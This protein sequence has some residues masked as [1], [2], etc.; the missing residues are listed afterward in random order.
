VI[1]ACLRCNDLPGQAVHLN[2]LIN[3]HGSRRDVLSY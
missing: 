1:R 3:P 2:H